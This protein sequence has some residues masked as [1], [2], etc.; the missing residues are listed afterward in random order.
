ML[1]RLD[2]KPDR[3][4][5]TPLLEGEV[6]E[7]SPFNLR[8]LV[9]GLRAAGVE[10]V[11][12]LALATLYA[13]T[14]LS[15]VGAVRVWA[16]VGGGRSILHYSVVTP[17]DLHMPWLDST[18]SGVE[19]GGCFTVPEARG[20]RLYPYVLDRIAAWAGESRPIYM[21]VEASNS[22][23][24]AGMGRAG[25]AVAGELRREGRLARLPCYRLCH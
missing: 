11:K 25:F 7:F 24:R 15:Q 9:T 13:A 4:A 14:H 10:Y 3:E 23:S 1:Y 16:Y 17:T 19:I 2:P 21:I 20:K 5:T 8:W 12:M 22:A 6:V 18:Q